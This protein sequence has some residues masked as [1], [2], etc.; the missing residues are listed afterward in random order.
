MLSLLNRKWS[1]LQSQK[2][3]NSI[4]INNF[5]FTP[6]WPECPSGQTYSTVPWCLA[7]CPSYSPRTRTP[8]SRAWW[9]TPATPWR[10]S[11]PSTPG[12]SLWSISPWR[13]PSPTSKARPEKRRGS[14]PIHPPA[15]RFQPRG[16]GRSQQSSP[17]HRLRLPRHHHGHCRQQVINYY[18]TLIVVQYT[19]S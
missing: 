11:T 4:K 12:S 17:R 13:R 9:R 18:F 7:L 5:V 10:T 15:T 8:P 3:I 16:R 6:S 14:G 2:E 19:C 1:R